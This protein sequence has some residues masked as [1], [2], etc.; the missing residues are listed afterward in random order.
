MQ[1]KVSKTS[2]KAS[3][4]SLQ[5]KP[6]DAEKATLQEAPGKRRAGS[7]AQRPEPLTISRGRKLV[8]NLALA[9]LLGILLLAL[10]FWMTGFS[11]SFLQAPTNQPTLS[12]LSSSPSTIGSSIK[13]HGERFSRYAIVALLR[14][15][16]PAVDSNGWRLAVNADNT[17][18]FTTTLLITPDWGIGNHTITG[19]DTTSHQRAVLV[20]LVESTSDFRGSP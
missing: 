3:K 11:F 14:D 19:E 16:Q 6:G 10:T 18:A 17:G 13:I 1:D 15:G 9:V 12:L 7:I 2:D 20:V 4:E 5:E 8:P